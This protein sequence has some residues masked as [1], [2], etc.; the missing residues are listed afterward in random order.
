VAPE[1]ISRVIG[2][3]IGPHAGPISGARIPVYG[4][5]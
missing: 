3:L 4:D 1:A 2:F 5:A